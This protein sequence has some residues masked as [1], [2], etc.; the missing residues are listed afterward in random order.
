VSVHQIETKFAAVLD[1]LVARAVQSGLPLSVAEKARC[2]T[3]RALQVPPNGR[4]TAFVRRRAEAYFSAVVQRSVVRGSAGPEAAARLVAAA[5]V[6]DLREAGRDESAIWR[7]LEDGWSARLPGD[8]LEEYRLRL[9][10]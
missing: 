3:R 6:A 1:T 7:E 10:G 4:A 9:C 5:V 8:V 2:A